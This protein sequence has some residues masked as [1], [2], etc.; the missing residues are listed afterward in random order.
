MRAIYIPGDFQYKV[1]DTFTYDGESFHHL[2]NV[3]RI[4]LGESL[5][6]L[7]GQGIS[8][9]TGVM[10]ISKKYGIYGERH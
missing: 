6:I 10:E 2:K 1:G 8:L 7:N 3:I 5:L 9:T 4:K